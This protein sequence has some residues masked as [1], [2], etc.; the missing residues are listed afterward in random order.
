MSYHGMT[1]HAL[2][3][4]CTDSTIFLTHLFPTFQPII[5][6]NRIKIRKRNNTISQYPLSTQDHNTDQDLYLA[7]MNRLS[8]TFGTILQTQ[9]PPAPSSAIN[10]KSYWK[11][12][13]LNPMSCWR[14]SFKRGFVFPPSATSTS[15]DSESNFSH[16]GKV[17]GGMEFW[18]GPPIVEL[19]PAGSR[20]EDAHVD[21]DVDVDVD[22]NDDR[23]G[24]EGKEEGSSSIS[25][26]EQGHGDGERKDD[27]L[28]NA[29][30][31]RV[32]LQ[33]IPSVFW[34]EQE[35]D[36]GI[37]LRKDDMVPLS[38]VFEARFEPEARE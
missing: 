2:L 29:N 19:I 8:T 34:Q 27:T 11:K 13:I 37:H 7:V 12:D 5:N 20:L 6:N 31:V 18:T 35:S 16:G 3:Q 24:G 23:R 26:E 32:T 17:K 10:K 21:A 22:S 28:S 14:V 30:F 1:W 38:L 15:F 33:G 25:G 36:L 9:P 4:L